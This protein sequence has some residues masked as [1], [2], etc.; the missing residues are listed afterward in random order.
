MFT[1]ISF[2][3]NSYNFETGIQNKSQQ[4]RLMLKLDY[5]VQKYDIQ[6]NYTESNHNTGGNSSSSAPF[7]FLTPPKL[8]FF[9]NLQIHRGTCITAGLKMSKIYLITEKWK[10]CWTRK[11]QIFK[12]TQ[13]IQNTCI[14][15]SML[16]E[17]GTYWITKWICRLGWRSATSFC[18]EGNSLSKNIE[19]NVC[20]LYKFDVYL[21][22]TK[23]NPATQILVMQT[24]SLWTAEAKRDSQLKL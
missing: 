12:N 22:K 2:V 20:M 17:K 19:R 11:L 18:F 5:V 16:R 15:S 9:L 6:L 21:R 14:T 24:D 8:F 13:W 10:H 23:Q 1:Y 7:T 3:F 4:T